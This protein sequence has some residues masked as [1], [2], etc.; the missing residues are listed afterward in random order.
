MQQKRSFVIE[1]LRND[2]SLIL[3]NVR[4]HMPLLSTS[5]GSSDE[6]PHVPCNEDPGGFPF[7]F[8]QLDSVLP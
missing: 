5:H 2:F 8:P 4:R 7:P 3:Q 6:D 1:W